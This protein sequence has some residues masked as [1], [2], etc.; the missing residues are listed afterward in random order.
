MGKPLVRNLAGRPFRPSSTRNLH[1]STTTPPRPRQLPL[2]WRNSTTSLTTIRLG[3]LWKEENLGRFRKSPRDFLTWQWFFDIQEFGRC[4]LQFKHG[5]FPLP[6]ELTLGEH[7]KVVPQNSR[8][9][10][11]FMVYIGGN[12]WGR[13]CQGT[14]FLYPHEVG[15]ELM[16][17]EEILLMELGEMKHSSTIH[18]D[19][20]LLKLH[21]WCMRFCPAYSRWFRSWMPYFRNLDILH[22]HGMGS[23]RDSDA[24]NHSEA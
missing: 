10:I 4:I 9:P 21:W 1:P 19:K 17:M 2:R 18:G 3:N 7:P 20:K 15:R 24:Q 23:K 5:D 11:F 8:F 13:H 6:C 16:L 12:V 14:F 22:P